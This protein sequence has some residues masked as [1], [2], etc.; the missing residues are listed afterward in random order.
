MKLAITSTGESLQSSVDPRFGRAKF[1][2]LTETG[3]NT[4]TVLHNSVNLNAAQGTGIQAAKAI[5]DLSVQALITG[6]VG[7][8]AFA[9]LKAGG[10]AVYPIAGGTVAEALDQFRSGAL[11]ALTAADVEGHW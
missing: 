8:K 6:H 7:P 3:A 1:F 10:V 4:A 2:V 9:A 11:H 5:I